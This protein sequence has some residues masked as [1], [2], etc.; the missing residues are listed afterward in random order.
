M[1]GG[2]ATCSVFSRDSN[3]VLLANK[4]CRIPIK[5][6]KCYKSILKKNSS[7]NEVS[8]FL[9]WVHVH[10]E[11]SELGVHLLSSTCPLTQ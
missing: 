7:E 10:F 9:K 5:N 1:K 2:G 11:L 8:N 6:T 3:E 4:I